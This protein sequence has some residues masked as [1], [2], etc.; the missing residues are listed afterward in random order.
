MTP[1]L[2]FALAVA[3]ALGPADTGEVTRP[4]ET[5]TTVWMAAADYGFEAFTHGLA[6]WQMWTARIERRTPAVAVALEATDASR[7]ALWDQQAALDAYPK[8][9][10][11]AYGNLRVAVAP[12]ARVLPRSDITGEIYQAVGRAWEISA[13]YRRMNYPD[14]GVNLWGVSVARYMPHWYVVAR[15]TA[16]P[17]SGRLGGGAWLTVRRYLATTDDYVDLVGGSGSEVVTLGA[18]STVVNHSQF[19]AG[20][21]QQS[22][23]H[24][25]ALTAGGTWTSQQGLPTRSGLTLGANYRW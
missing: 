20:R 18:G 14:R 5:D 22:L 23:S 3:P 19:F 8:L 6:A 1:L 4:R 25:L 11:H 16:V 9:W 2:V 7:F 15:A 21:L 13:S 17:L 24:R 10:R 12:G